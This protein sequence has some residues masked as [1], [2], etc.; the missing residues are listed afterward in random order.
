MA[1]EIRAVE[2]HDLDALRR[3]VALA[4]G[5]DPDPAEEERDRRLVELDRN[6]GAYDGAR[7]VGSAGAY[8]L[9]LT[10]PGGRV[11]AAGVSNVTVLPSHRRQGLMRKMM[12]GMLADARSRGDALSVLWSSE[13]PLYGRF[14]FGAATITSHLVV[15]RFPLLPHRLAPEPAPVMILDPGDARE[16]L[17]LLFDRK[18]R[19]VPG[20]FARSPAWW[21]LESLGDYAR[22]RK[23]AS[24]YRYAVALDAAGEGVG[25]VQYRT[26]GTWEGISMGIDVDLEEIIAL[27][28]EAYSGLWG[29]L[30]NQDLIR[31]LSAWNIPVETALQDVFSNFRDFQ[32]VCD[33]LWVRILDV[34]AALSERRYS[35]DGA[36]VFEVVD[37]VGE[38]RTRYRLEVTEGVGVCRAVSDTPDIILDAEDLGSGYLGRSR[39]RRLAGVGR[40]DGAPEALALAD[41]MFDWHPQP[42]C[43][44][45]F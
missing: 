22:H 44:E 26:E 1:V 43:Q 12:T 14:G 6:R 2:P 29:F 16:V 9:D 35:A 40:L 7:L 36:L 13:A 33:G 3:T 28:P 37:P 34:E 32:T 30:V 15:D 24:T 27:T 10:V 42:W 31:K 5:Q 23:S 18:R 25:Y 20:M 4:F 11:P 8:S 41:A 45:V 39:F 19:E 21:E 38:D 17:P